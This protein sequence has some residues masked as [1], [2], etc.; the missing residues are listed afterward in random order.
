MYQTQ[1]STSPVGFKY[2]FAHEYSIPALKPAPGASSSFF[3]SSL[4]KSKGSIPNL[5]AVARSNRQ[6]FLSSVGGW[7]ESFR[8]H[9]PHKALCVG[10]LNPDVHSPQKEPFLRAPR[11]E[12]LVY[13]S[14]YK[15]P[16]LDNGSSSQMVTASGGSWHCCITVL[17]YFLERNPTRTS[18]VTSNTDQTLTREDTPVKVNRV[19]TVILK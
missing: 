14:C 8:P 4:S 1:P 6:S 10:L 17:P 5:S 12:F 15:V 3:H 19:P 9:R 11:V 18:Q 16:C 7:H 13:H 2:S